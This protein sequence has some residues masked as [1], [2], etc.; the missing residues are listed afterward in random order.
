ML[1]LLKLTSKTYPFPLRRHTF[2]RPPPHHSSEFPKSPTSLHIYRI[3]HRGRFHAGRKDLSVG[4]RSDMA[5]NLTDS[6]LLANTFSSFLLP[7]CD[8]SCCDCRP[9]WTCLRPVPRF[10]HFF[11]IFS[12]HI[13]SCTRRRHW[14]WQCGLTKIRFQCGVENFPVIAVRVSKATTRNLI[15]IL[16]DWCDIRAG[17]HAKLVARSRS[18]S[19]G[20]DSERSVSTGCSRTVRVRI[21]EV[22]EQLVLFNW[23]G[24]KRNLRRWLLVGVSWCFWKE[25]RFLAF[26]SARRARCPSI[27]CR[28]SGW[29]KFAHRKCVVTYSARRNAPSDDWWSSN[30][31][32]EKEWFGVSEWGENRQ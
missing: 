20:D 10:Y 4:G 1:S 15:L 11:F 19:I 24:R 8:Y 12:V 23:A 3:A 25:V 29:P 18:S 16:R 21:F 30:A 9:N 31:V 2:Q 17:A 6:G 14:H 26:L 22:W 7:A 32:R 27:S 5:S 13:F 28:R